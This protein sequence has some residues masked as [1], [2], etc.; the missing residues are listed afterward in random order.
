M[1]VIK[2][3]TKTTTG[4]RSAKKMSSPPKASGTI[5]IKA[6]ASAK[7]VKSTKASKLVIKEHQ[8]RVEILQL[9]ADKTNL[10]R[11]EVEAVFSQ[12]ADIVKAHMAQNGSGEVMIPKLGLKIR[13]VRRKAT[14]KRKMVSPLTG[15]EVI[16]PAKPA[17]DDVKLIALKTLKEAVV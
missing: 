7:K 15:N 9:I 4:S 14:K 12:M 2:R 5:K 10:K 11:V 3:T 8:T 6:Q 17:R 13:K 16:I 1:S